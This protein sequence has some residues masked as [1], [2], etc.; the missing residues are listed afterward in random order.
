MAILFAFGK[1]FRLVDDNGDHLVDEN[2]N[3]LSVNHGKFVLK[4]NHKI[5]V[6]TETQSN[7][8]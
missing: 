1:D 4:I 3:I 7:A 2:G 5:L 6:K 8:T